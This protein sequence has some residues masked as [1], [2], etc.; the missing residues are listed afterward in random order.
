MLSKPIIQRLSTKSLA[1][2]NSV[3]AIQHTRKL[4]TPSAPQGM[5]TTVDA[6]S[7]PLSAPKDLDNKAII[8][9]LGT[10]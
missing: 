4:A 10:D 2:K 8:A 9:P 7:G 5:A 6:G 1:S 3:R